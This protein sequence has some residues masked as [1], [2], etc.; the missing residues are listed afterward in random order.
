MEQQQHQALVDLQNAVLRKVR[1]VLQGK[2]AASRASAELAVT[3]A[4]ARTLHGLSG[5][6]GDVLAAA[7]QQLAEREAAGRWQYSSC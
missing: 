1:H 6:Q 3:R 5:M 4:D 2:A 7:V